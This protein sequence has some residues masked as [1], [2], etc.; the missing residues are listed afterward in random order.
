MQ[1]TVELDEEAAEAVRKALEAGVYTSPED[2][3]Q[4][5]IWE[6]TLARSP[7]ARSRSEIDVLLDEAFRDL[8]VN[9]AV[10]LSR[11]DIEGVKTRGRERL[12]AEKAAA[13]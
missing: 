1:V 3:V 11:D 10:P 5:A 13:E 2:V 6:W 4:E 9:G 7:D 12:A 8:E